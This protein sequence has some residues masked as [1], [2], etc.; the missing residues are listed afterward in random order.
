MIIKVN[1]LKDRFHREGVQINT[2][3]VCMINDEI[4]KLIENKV[5]KCKFNNIKRLTGELY[6]FS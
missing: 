1:K 3:A 2:I 6:H 5:N 4:E